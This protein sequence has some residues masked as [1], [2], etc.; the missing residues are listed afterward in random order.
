MQVYAD[1]T[2]TYAIDRVSVGAASDSTKA[3]WVRSALRGAYIDTT[4]ERWEVNCATLAYRTLRSVSTDTTA[5]ARTFDKWS[6]DSTWIER[7]PDSSME[8]IL[9]KV[10]AYLKR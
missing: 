5:A 2:A 10:C 4:R 8:A 7:V 3:V 9:D 1:S 6:A